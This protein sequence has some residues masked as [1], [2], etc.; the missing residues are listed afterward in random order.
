MSLMTGIILGAL[1]SSERV[2]ILM[3]RALSNPS[4]VQGLIFLVL[5]NLLMFLTWAFW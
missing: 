5:K 1:A 4:D 2:E 3:F